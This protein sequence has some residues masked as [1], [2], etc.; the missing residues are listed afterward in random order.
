M[1]GTNITTITKTQNYFV[2]N[3]DKKISIS[4]SIDPREYALT[5]VGVGDTIGILLNFDANS[6]LQFYINSVN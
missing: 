2:M 4:N 5:T 3:Q 6:S 1:A